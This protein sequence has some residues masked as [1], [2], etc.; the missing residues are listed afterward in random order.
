MGVIA[1]EI[2]FGLPQYKVTIPVNKYVAWSDRFEK[3]EL[4]KTV[5]DI[6]FSG[7]ELVNLDKKVSRRLNPIKNDIS[8]KFQQ[9]IEIY[10]GKEINAYFNETS[11][12]S[13]EQQSNILDY[14]LK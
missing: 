5:G 14:L 8:E 3:T 11:P 1:S 9:S 12:L 10:V 7:G 13:E 6:S 2:K 4:H